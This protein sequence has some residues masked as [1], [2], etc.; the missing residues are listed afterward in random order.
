MRHLALDDERMRGS[1]SEIARRVES[2]RAVK[3]SVE[4]MGIKTY[5]LS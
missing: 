4:V 2:D 1:R 5:N 3:I